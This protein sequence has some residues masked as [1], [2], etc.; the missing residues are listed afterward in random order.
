MKVVL[1][2]T[3]KARKDLE[4]LNEKLRER[5]ILRLEFFCYQSPPMHHA[6]PLLGSLRGLYR[7]R[8]GDYRIIFQKNAQG[9]LT[10]LTIIRIK[11][12]GDVYE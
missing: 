5:I 3:S 9:K 6:K 10:I 2:Y 7:F 1:Q 4:G 11:H 12:R 8:V